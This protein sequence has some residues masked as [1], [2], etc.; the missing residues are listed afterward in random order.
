[1]QYPGI[2]KAIE[3]DLKSISLLESMMSPISRKLN[4]KQTIDEIRTVFLSELD[5]SREASM[6]D[7]FRKAD[8]AHRDAG[9]V[10][11]MELASGSLEGRAVLRAVTADYLL[12]A[13]LEGSGSLGRMRFALRKAADALQPELA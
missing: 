11:P 13:A 12:V 6:A 4:S 9:L 1:V 5:Y 3:S 7:L 2:D 8:A 10:T